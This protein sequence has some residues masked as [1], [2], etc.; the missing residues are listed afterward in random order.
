M[1]NTKKVKKAI[2]RYTGMPYNGAMIQKGAIE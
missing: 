2:D 1:K